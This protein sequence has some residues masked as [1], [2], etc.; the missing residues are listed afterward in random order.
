M[1][2]DR[3][4]LLSFDVEEFDLPLEYNHIIDPGEQMLI[5]NKGLMEILPLLQQKELTTTLF[6]TANFAQH[7]PD[8]IKELAAKHE[9][10]SHTFYHSSF[11]TADLESSRNVLENIAGKPVTGLR[12]PRMLSIDNLDIQRAGYLYNSSLNP[13]WLPGRYN[14]LN[15]P[16]TVF[17]DDNLICLPVSV[18]PNFRI[19]LFWL[20]FKNLPYALFRKLALQT[21]KKDG[22]LSLYFHPWEF[23]DLSAYR[24]PGY[25]KR[26]GNKA[27]LNRLTQLIRD[28]SNEGD[29]IS[30]QE[31]LTHKNSTL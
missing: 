19:P 28:L 22:Y 30:I 5:G 7:Y 3:Y 20:S 8:I 16:R 24:I 23:I 13:T 14:H 21:L 18:T 2:K 25:I 26:H 15:K 12:M 1:E 10:G 31:Y 4:I 17:K 6:T 9:I 27:L 11:K 29:F